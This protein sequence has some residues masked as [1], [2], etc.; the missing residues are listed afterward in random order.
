MKPTPL[1]I[2]ARILARRRGE[3]APSFHP[4]EEAR[5]VRAHLRAKARTSREREVAEYLIRA[6]WGGAAGTGA[7]PIRV[8]F[9]FPTVRLGFRRSRAA[10]P[11]PLRKQMIT[12]KEGNCCQPPKRRP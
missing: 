5:A 3:E 2:L 6:A 10:P 4:E 1:V 12:N 9:R 11:L 7:Q 8:G